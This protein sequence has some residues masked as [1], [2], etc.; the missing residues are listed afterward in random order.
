MKKTIK[1][2]TKLVIVKKKDKAKI[3]SK[4]GKK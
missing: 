3:M 4:K 2:L 1:G